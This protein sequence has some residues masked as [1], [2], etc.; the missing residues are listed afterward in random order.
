MQATATKWAQE[1]RARARLR[2][3]QQFEQVAHNVSQTCRFFGISRTQL[4]IWLADT[5]KMVWRP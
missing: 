4:Y 2:M 1:H 3:I 5:G